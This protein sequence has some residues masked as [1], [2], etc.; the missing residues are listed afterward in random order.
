VSRIDD[1]LKGLTTKD[2]KMRDVYRHPSFNY[3][4]CFPFG[5]VLHRG[6]RWTEIHQLNQRCQGPYSIDKTELNHFKCMAVTFSDHRDAVW[7][8]LSP[9]GDLVQA[10]FN[11][12]KSE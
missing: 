7:F 12:D 3:E 5:F 11:H 9:M 4:Q 6:L 8:R 10:P 1:I 2:L